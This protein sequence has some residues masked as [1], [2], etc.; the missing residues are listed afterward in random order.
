M[1]IKPKVPTCAGSHAAMLEFANLRIREAGLPQPIE[2]G[3]KKRSAY[4]SIIEARRLRQ[5]YQLQSRL[6]R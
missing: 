6:P 2:T 1:T 3:I 4:A 5:S